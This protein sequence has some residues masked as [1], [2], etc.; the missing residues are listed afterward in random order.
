MSTS[1]SFVTIGFCLEFVE[2]D[3]D[4]ILLVQF[5]ADP[6][7]V[8]LNGPNDALNLANY[9]ITGPGTARGEID[10]I[11]SIDTNPQAVRIFL[12]K[13]LAIAG[14][15]TLSASTNIKTASALNLVSPTTISFSINAR[16][17]VQQEEVPVLVEASV[18]GSYYQW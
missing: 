9:T 14:S 16:P 8:D 12:K 18:P 13:P 6:L 7:R 4:L 2:Y 17:K 15:W 1:I 11:Q 10:S 3:D 5:T